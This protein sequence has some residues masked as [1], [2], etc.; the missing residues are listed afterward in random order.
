M[1]ARSVIAPTIGEVPSRS[2][3]GEGHVG[4]GCLNLRED[5]GDVGCAKKAGAVQWVKVAPGRLS[6]N[7]EWLERIS[8]PVKTAVHPSFFAR[9]RRR[10]L[11]SCFAPFLGVLIGVGL[12]LRSDRTGSRQASVSAIGKEPMKTPRGMLRPAQC[13]KAR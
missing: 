12:T 1:P 10:H 6:L 3:L 4:T 11:V 13:P 9:V 7:R 5:R 2:V 8:F